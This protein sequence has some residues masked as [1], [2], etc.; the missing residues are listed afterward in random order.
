L[1]LPDLRGDY[2]VHST[3]SDDAESTLA[4]NLVAAAD[5]GLTHIRLV[6]HVRRSTTWLPDFVAALAG[7]ERPEGLVVHNGVEAKLLDAAGSLDVPEDLAGIETILIA[8]HQF[9]GPEGP[10]SPEE[11]RR[12]LDGGLAVGEALDMLIGAL[13]AAMEATGAA[14]SNQ[15]AQLAHCF[16]ILPKIGLDED[17]LSDGQL[18]RWASAAA[19]TGTLV[20]VNEKWACPGPRALEAAVAADVTLVAATD[21]HV[22]TDVGRYRR[23]AELIGQVGAR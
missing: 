15:S 2:H 1:S 23:V 7:E 13:V 8:D 19:T 3:F 18:A 11:T 16:S 4:E 20:E 12:R 22:A 6:E 17:Q 10:W 14:G 5:R 9:P 21:S